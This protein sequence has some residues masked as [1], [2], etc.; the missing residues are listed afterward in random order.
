MSKLEEE[1]VRIFVS[2]LRHARQI[3][4][5]VI[6]LAKEEPETVLRA[7]ESL[8]ERDQKYLKWLK[9]IATRYMPGN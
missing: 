9:D 7:M 8:E 2:D 1:A 4:Q 6:R 3:K 5:R